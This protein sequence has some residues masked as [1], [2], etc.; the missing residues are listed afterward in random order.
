[1]IFYDMFLKFKVKN[2]YVWIG[3]RSIENYWNNDI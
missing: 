3:L 2:Q 1:M